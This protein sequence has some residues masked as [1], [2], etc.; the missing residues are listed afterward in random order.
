[1]RL[2]RVAPGVERCQR[3]ETRQ[4]RRSRRCSGWRYSVMRVVGHL[5]VAVAPRPSGGV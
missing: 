4:G 1:G 2:A 3:A 5:P